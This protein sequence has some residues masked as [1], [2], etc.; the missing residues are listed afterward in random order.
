MMTCFPEKHMWTCT[1]H[2]L[3]RNNLVFI[4]E[5]H[6]HISFLARIM[7]FAFFSAGENF[8]LLFLQVRL[9]SVE[10]NLVEVRLDR[11]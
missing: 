8:L 2:W 7:H 10:T 6:D 4:V 9:V 11:D 3:L 1:C 5:K